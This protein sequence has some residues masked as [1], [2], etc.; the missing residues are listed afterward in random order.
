MKDNTQIQVRSKFWATAPIRVVMYI[1]GGIQ[2]ND[3][4]F[5]WD[6]FFAVNVIVENN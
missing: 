2:V 1:N 4:W 6:Y 3:N 5:T